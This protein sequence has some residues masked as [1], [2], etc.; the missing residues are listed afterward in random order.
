[1]TGGAIIGLSVLTIVIISCVIALNNETKK[2]DKKGISIGV[3]LAGLLII[4]GSWA[5]GIWYFN[6]TEAGKRAL[7]TQE[8]NFNGGIKRRVT[9]YDVEGDM[10][11]EYEGK[12]DI[13]YD[14]DR[15]LFDDEQGLRHIIYYPTGNVIIDE[16]E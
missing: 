9:V 6:G 13:E 1:M 8:S 16:L 4:I 10:I 2:K 5:I 12:F 14:D 7:K 15:I 11:A 3:T